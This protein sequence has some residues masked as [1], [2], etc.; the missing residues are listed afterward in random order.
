MSSESL[1]AG[2][3]DCVV[4]AGED[5]FFQV[6]VLG[7]FGESFA[8]GDFCGLWDGI[9]V[10]SAADGGEGQRV[11]V[12]FTGQSETGSVTTGE[13][14]RL[15]VRPAIPHRAD[16][17]EDE[18]G[19]KSKAFGQLRVAGLASAK[20][21]TLMEQVR[22]GGAVDCAINAAAAE[23]GPVGGVDDGVDGEGSDVGLQDFDP[24]GH[25]L[26]TFHCR[27]SSSGWR[28]SEFRLQTRR[29]QRLRV[30]RF[31]QR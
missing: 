23:Q 14:F 29:G 10:Y 3:V 6:G 4:E 16:G 27:G 12:M 15:V 9:A 24:T 1:C 5:Y 28:R 13:E 11:E 8:K 26:I 22:A 7:E 17:V 30:R 21:T 19:G 18:A 20:Q 25:L 2:A 31:R